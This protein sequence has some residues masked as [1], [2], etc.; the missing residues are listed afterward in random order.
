MWRLIIYSEDHQMAD[1]NRECKTTDSMQEHDPF[2]LHMYTQAYTY[3]YQSPEVDAANICQFNQFWQLICLV[4]Q[5]I[6]SMLLYWY[7]MN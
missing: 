5:S 6:K 3:H 4:N 2:D 1:K 7:I